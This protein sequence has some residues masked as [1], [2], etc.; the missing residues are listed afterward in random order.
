MRPFSIRVTR[1]ERIGLVGANG[2]GKTTLVNLLTGALQPDTGRGRS[3]ETAAVV[4]LDQR[5]RA[6]TATGRCAR[7]SPTG[8]A[9]GST[10]PASASTRWVPA[11]LPVHARAG[12]HA[13][14]GALR[15]ERARLML[16]RALARPSN[17]MVLDEP[18]NDLDLET[19]DLLQEMIA[20]YHGTV[21]LVSHDRDFLDR[22]VDSV[23]MAEGDGRFH[24]L[25]RRLLRH[26]RPARRGREGARR[27]AGRAGARA[28]A[29]REGR[30]PA[31][32]QRRRCPSRTSTRSRRCPR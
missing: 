19:L 29:G 2:A 14:Q 21:L 13:G 17:L 23:I 11:R 4:T 26:D 31:A 18:T 15:G 28:P 6:S 25:C 8:A 12:A 3:R 32:S 1:G 16:A 20:D 22:T 10:S 7:R 30:R 5:A 27:C 9:T 24:D